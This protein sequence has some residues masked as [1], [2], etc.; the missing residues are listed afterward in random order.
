[1]TSE[2]RAR[3]S[4][5]RRELTELPDFIAL[6][7]AEDR[8]ALP[9]LATRMRVLSECASIVSSVFC[10]L[11]DAQLFLDPKLFDAFAERGPGDAEDF[12]SVDLVAVGFLERLN[13]QFALDFG[14]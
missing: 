13:D 2:G 1:M 8:R 11:F 12:R 10:G 3:L 6:R 7:R 14:D 4:S 9:R 5:S